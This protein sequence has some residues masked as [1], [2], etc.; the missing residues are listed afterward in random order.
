MFKLFGNPLNS[1]FVVDEPPETVSDA[2]L[3]KKTDPQ[4]GNASGETEVDLFSEISQILKEQDRLE[5][6]AEDLRSSQSNS[7]K[8]EMRRFFKANLML[9]DGFDRIL[10]MSQSLPPNSGLE[11]WLKS[12]AALQSRMIKSYERFGL[13]IMDP[14]GKPVDLDRHEV[15]EIFHTDSIPDET[16]VE[17]RQRGYLFDGKILRDAQVV[18]AKNERT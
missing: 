12:I 17:V 16:V 5:S 11:N 15:I 10:Q 8:E 14:V 3:R 9:L 7:G 1:E 13:R 18:V 4:N 6:V 2:P